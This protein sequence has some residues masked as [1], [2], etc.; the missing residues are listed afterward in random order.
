MK[1]MDVV[2]RGG[3]IASSTD[4]F[5]ADV[6]ILHGSIVAVGKDLPNAVRNID[7]RD[8]IVLPGGIDSHAHIEQLS[9]SGLMTADDFES[10]TTSAAF[11]GTT[12]VISFAAQHRGMD[13]A[14][15]VEEYHVA[16]KRGAVI[17]HAFHMIIADPTA[18][19]LAAIPDLVRDGHASLKIF[20]TYDRLRL[21]DDQ[22]LDVL[23]AARASKALVCVHAENNG[24][25]SWLSKRLVERGYTAPKYHT[26]SHPRLSEAEAFQRLIAMAEFIDQP[27]MI[28]H[29]STAEG[30]AVVREARGRGVKVFAETCPHYLLLTAADVDKPGLEGAKWC[31]S[32]PLRTVGDQEALWA[33]LARR[34]LQVISSDHAPYAYDETGKLKHGPASTF[35]QIANGLPGLEVRLPLMFDAMVSRGRMSL[36]DFVDLTATQPAKIYGL[37]PR[38][39]TIAVGADADIVLWDPARTQTL[40]AATLHDRTGY[41]PFE[42]RSVTGYPT[43]VLRRG[44]V[45]I[46]NGRLLAKPGS[47]RFLGRD[48]GP[49][50]EPRGVFPPE[51]E[52]AMNFGAE[53]RSG[54]V[55]ARRDRLT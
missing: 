28:F 31:C 35:K 55:R 1:N 2:I 8:K 38:K 54:V 7:A 11:G 24:M 26:V 18:E 33:A 17:D 51:F 39:G 53:L 4:I 25:I 42:G 13:L 27:I 21:E 45:I 15:V 41:S 14:K 3:T 36:T 52:P 46:E 32:P 30:A 29:V 20:M 6:G 10:A 16:A 44:E 50:A 22:V 48:A 9:A 23:T 12:T 37:Y 19:T 49:A 5:V 34:D 43:T 40:Q 47:G